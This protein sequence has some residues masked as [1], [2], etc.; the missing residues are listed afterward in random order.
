MIIEAENESLK[1]VR[2]SAREF[3]EA[4]L[5]P[6]A[7]KWDEEEAIPREVYTEAAGL[8]FLGMML[9]EEYGGLNL[10]YPAYVAAMEELARGNA[11]FQVGITVHNSL[12]GSAIL[13]FGTGEQKRKYLPKMAKGE[14]IGAYCLSEPGAGSDAG[15]L[16]TSAVAD[17]GFYVIN[18]TKAWVSNGGFADVFLVFVSTNRELKNKGISCLIVDKGLQ[19]L[20]IG[21]K[22]KKLGIKASDTRELSFQNCEVPKSALLGEE[23]AG[24]KVA[25]TQLDNGRISIASQAIGIAQAAFEEAVSY[26]QA[27]SQF[28]KPIADFQATQFKIADMA[29]G[30]DAARLLTYRAAGLMA[31]GIRCSKEA[32]MAKLFASEMCNR[33]VFDA[34]Q[35]HGG[36]GY[37]RE[38]PVER[39]FRDARITEIYEG[40]SEIQRLI[41]ARE[42]L[43]PRSN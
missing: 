17:G 8:G 2:E 30:L 34:V 37:T 11:A 41:I 22:E 12:V 19:G 20:S 25:M 18:G 13:R 38:F 28:G 29:V 43:N 6:N 32:S 1:I 26:S 9:P 4:R 23:N 31:R 24:F 36:N 42:V 7:R 16:K 33:T 40:T 3:A 15:S 5:K 14:W 39:Y 35:L 10:D 27:R 21:K